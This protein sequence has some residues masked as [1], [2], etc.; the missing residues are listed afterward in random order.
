MSCYIL[1]VLEDTNAGDPDLAWGTFAEF[2]EDF[3]PPPGMKLYGGGF[4]TESVAKIVNDPNM[5]EMIDFCYGEGTLQ[6]DRVNR[7]TLSV[8]DSTGTGAK[9]SV[10]PEK[11]LPSKY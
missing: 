1:I 5:I 7:E 6:R 4:I 9:I 8:I 3:E 2:A 10:D 11:I